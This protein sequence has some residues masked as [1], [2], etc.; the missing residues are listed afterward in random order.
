MPSST[1][2]SEGC[3]LTGALSVTTA[4]HG[5]ISLVHGPEGCAHH[6]ASLLFSQFLEQGDIRIPSVHSTCLTAEGVIF[7][8]EECLRSAIRSVLARSPSMV[9]LLST[10]VSDMIGD[11]CAA[12]A[13]E[14]PEVPVVPVATGGFLGGTFNDGVEQALVTIVSGI[15]P[16]EP[17]PGEVCLVGEKNL[18]F[19]ADAQYLEVRRL[20]SLLGL[21][22]SVRLVRDASVEELR[23][24]GSASLFVQRDPG[25]SRV[26]EYIA[27]RFNAPVIR[28]FPAGFSGTLSFLQQAG[29]AAGRDP[30]PAIRAEQQRQKALLEEFA[31]LRGTPAALPRESDRPSQALG[32]EI[33]SLLDLP[34]RD[35]APPLPVGDPFPVGTTGV[36]RVLHR[37]RRL[38]R[39]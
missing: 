25:L 9:F 12:V 30:G 10:C 28:S 19:E 4:V 17:V 3:S 21:T 22:P 13:A 1:C 18:E 26:G 36:A 38:V 8:G 27:Q 23:R 37:W 31:N 24:A 34:L 5:A 29:N 35:G 33:A 32:S 2:R 20:L 7:G 14:F 11:D 16:A 15:T 6:T 39:A